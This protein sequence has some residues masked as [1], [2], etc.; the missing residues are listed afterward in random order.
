MV[1]FLRDMRVRE[2]TFGESITGY[3]DHMCLGNQSPYVTISQS[4]FAD[5]NEKCHTIDDTIFVRQSIP[6]CRDHR[7]E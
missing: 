7:N 2:S 5:M 6:V 3:L 4:L 1:L